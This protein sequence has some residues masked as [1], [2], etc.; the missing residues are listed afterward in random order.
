MM[1]YGSRLMTLVPLNPHQV[2][3]Q[4]KA[5]VPN[6]QQGQFNF[7]GIYIQNLFLI[8]D[9]LIYPSRNARRKLRKRA[10]IAS[11]FLPLTLAKAFCLI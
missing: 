10:E 1:I 11:K 4:E 9:C 8:R 7:L 3:K 6:Q 2:G 5:H